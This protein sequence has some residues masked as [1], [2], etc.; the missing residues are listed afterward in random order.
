MKII[1]VVHQAGNSAQMSSSSV[2]TKFSNQGR[3]NAF[4]TPA[5]EHCAAHLRGVN[6]QLRAQSC[7]SD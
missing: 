6:A 7:P 2:H 4:L 3:T 1:V 5:N